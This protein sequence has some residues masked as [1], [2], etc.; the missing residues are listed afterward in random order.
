MADRRALRFDNLDAITDDVRRL[1]AGHVAGGQWTLPMACW[2]L[3]LATDRCLHMPATTEPTDAERGMQ[4]RLTDLFAAGAMPPGLPM[5]PGTEPPTDAGESSIDGFLAGLERL[6]AYSHSHVTF[7]PFGPVTTSA[8]RGFMELH[9][10]NHL[11]CFKP[12]HGTERRIGLKFADVNAMI[13]DIERLRRGHARTGRWTLPQI[14]WHLKLA[15]P[16]PV[17]TLAAM[18]E[19]TEAQSTRQQR[20]DYYIANGHP[21]VGFEAPAEMTPPGGANDEDVDALLSLLRELDAIEAPVVV[22]AAGA[23]PIAR[24]RGFIL[25]HG[26]HHLSY[27][28]P[29]AARRTDVRFENFEALRREIG[30]L[31]GGYVRTGNWSLEQ[32]CFHLDQTM[33]VAMKPG[34]YDSDTPEQLARGEMFKEVMRT[35]VLPSGLVSPGFAHPPANTPASAIDAYLG[36][37][38]RFEK[39]PGPFAPHRLFG[40]LPPDVRKQH[41]L[42]HAAHHLSYLI[43]T[44]QGQ[45]ARGEGLGKT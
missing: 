29:T 30:T 18:P 22:T 34:P 19:L 11:S 8:F 23:M 25:A 7:G 14:A 3:K 1:R 5:F 15:Y 6:K 20:W 16:R 32:A 10:A 31:R 9:S 37:L 4:Q 17:Q 39:H 44:N 24:A 40:N 42:I 43:P 35:G 41:Q 38:D 27:L 33:A 45:G 12:T 28:V 36:T 21:P 2:H 13:V 26:A